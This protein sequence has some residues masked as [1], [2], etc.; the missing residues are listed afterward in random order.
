MAPLLLFAVL[1]LPV[2]VAITFPEA[3]HGYAAWALERDSFYLNR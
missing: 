3:A 1:A 2:I